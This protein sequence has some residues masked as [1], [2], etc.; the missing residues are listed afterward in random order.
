MSRGKYLS[1]EEARKSGALDRFAKEHPMEA[2][3]D[4]FERLLNAMSQGALEEE[5]TSNP[6]RRANSNGTRTR[7]GT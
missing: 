3:R 6:D 4:R 2:D 5:E 1:L 7:R